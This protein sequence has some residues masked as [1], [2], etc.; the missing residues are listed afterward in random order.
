MTVTTMW[1]EKLESD[2]FWKE[3]EAL[4]P[5]FSWGKIIEDPDATRYEVTLSVRTN[6]DKRSRVALYRGMYDDRD[7]I[8]HRAFSEAGAIERAIK[9]GR[10]YQVR[11]QE[12]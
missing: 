5:F 2:E 11:S 10:D 7:R 1:G 3:E 9:D 8:R 6:D 4:S 12:E